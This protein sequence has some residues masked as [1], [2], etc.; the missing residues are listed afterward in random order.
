MLDNPLPYA[1]RRCGRLRCAIGGADHRRGDDARMLCGIDDIERDRGRRGRHRRDR[2]HM[3]RAAAGDE[4]RDQLTSDAHAQALALNLDLAET[5]FVEQ[6]RQLADQV[7][8]AHT[9]ARF[10]EG[11][12]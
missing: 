12:E 11:S 8:F 7:L 10:D 1:G 2:G 4:I 9:V 5:G 3:G 6:F